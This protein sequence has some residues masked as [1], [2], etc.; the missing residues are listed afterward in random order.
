MYVKARFIRESHREDFG[1]SIEVDNAA[2]Y[3]NCNIILA[4]WPGCPCPEFNNILAVC[5]GAIIVD[6]QLTILPSAGCV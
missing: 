4:G 1:R 5:P 3:F 6:K 2:D